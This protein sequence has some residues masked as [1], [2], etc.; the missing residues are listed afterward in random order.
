[1]TDM[2]RLLA[3]DLTGAPWKKS[4]RSGGGNGDCVETTPL[5]VSSDV[6][7]MGVRDSK[8]PDGPV[9]RFSADAWSAFMA[10]V[11]RGDLPL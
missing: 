6:L 11:E 10:S 8:D 4:T 2:T 3:A 7:G 1:M 5:K 9:L